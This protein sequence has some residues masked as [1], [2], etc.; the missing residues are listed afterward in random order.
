MMI[1]K[2]IK[3]N[4]AIVDFILSEIQAK[5]YLAEPE[6][7]Q[8]KVNYV[9]INGFVDVGDLPCR[10][11]FW[12]ED[13]G[14]DIP[15]HNDQKW[16]YINYRPS[17]VKVDSSHFW[18]RPTHI[19]RWAK[20]ILK[21]NESGLYRF[22]ITTCGGMYIWVNGQMVHKF[23]VYQRNS[24]KTEEIQLSLQKGNNEIIIFFDDIAER[25]T[26]FYFKMQYLDDKPLYN[27]FCDNAG[28]DD[29]RTY[30]D[31]IQ[32]INVS[33]LGDQIILTNAEAPLS[34]IDIRCRFFKHPH[35][36]ENV[37]K[38][39]LTWKQDEK[40][41]KVC[42]TEF[43]GSG[44]WHCEIA[45]KL[46]QQWI[47][48][49]LNLT[50]MPEL[51]D[52]DHNLDRDARFKR[53][54]AY[55]AQYGDPKIGRVLSAF[56][57]GI[58]DDEICTIIDDT[59]KKISQRHDCSDFLI[60][61]LLCIWKKY[62]GQYLPPALWKRIKSTIL[63]WRYWLDEPGN[64]VMWFWS[65]NHCLCFHVAQY[66]A[67]SIFFDELFIC[68][69]K[70]GKEQQDIAYERL[71]KWFDHIEDNGFIEW[72]SIAYYPIDL[73]GLIAL[74]DYAPD[75]AM[76]KKSQIAMDQLFTMIAIHALKGRAVG[77]MGRAYEKELLSSTVNELSTYVH[78]LWGGGVMNK[79]LSSLSLL[80]AG[81][82]QVPLYTD[83]LANWT[84]DDAFE[85]RYFQGINQQAKL[86][87]WKN[88]DAVLSTVIDHQC[89]K[90]GHQQHIIDLSFAA[91]HEAKIWI[92]HPGELEPGGEARPSFW[93]GNGI[94]PR[95]NQYRNRAL[96]IMNHPQDNIL[97]SHMYF[98]HHAFDEVI[99]NDQSIFFRCGDGYGAVFASDQLEIL[100]GKSELRLNQPQSAWYICVGSKAQDRG[101][102]NFTDKLRKN[103]LKLADQTASFDDPFTGKMQLSWGGDF[104]HNNMDKVPENWS[105]TPLISLDSHKD[106]YFSVMELKE[107]IQ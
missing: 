78:V 28:D 88:N 8:D 5:L 73:I 7:M 6:I 96:I 100:S 61:P 36:N 70:T 43:L 15:F 3:K 94:L 2:L 18:H 31:F 16:A 105:P 76:R 25:D 101:F 11:K 59:L 21:V 23:L 93:A 32:N 14:R 95:V 47:T 54:S 67:G 65:E 81:N 104:H 26:Y 66:L 51:L 97:F 99:H 68:N 33:I 64:D 30:G 79:S 1:N 48:K 60:I 72:N 20:T 90:K 46:N 35:E 86:V 56:E 80:L 39:S 4:N 19:S 34:D 49:K 71:L 84:Q 91:H 50:I 37:N 29:I 83:I 85:A 106:H 52:D 53:T 102:E 24:E 74:Y 77:S 107:H 10:K 63:G 12:Q 87:S 45:Y 38:F 27:Y 13:M 44:F 57:N 40:Q 22:D 9:F 92:N 103:I 42:N 82:Y 41:T 17:E 69:N 75:Q 55:L 89:G 58:C 98:P 62:A